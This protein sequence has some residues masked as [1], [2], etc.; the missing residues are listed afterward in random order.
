MAGTPLSEVCDNFMMITKD[1][2]LITLY[3]TSSTDFENYLEG[4]LVSAIKDFSICD[5]SVAYATGVFTETLTQRNIS[6]LAKMMKKYWLEKEVADITQ[7]NLHITDRDYKT[8]SEAQNLTAKKSI[9]ILE[10]E[11]IS[12]LLVNYSLVTNVDWASW[13]AGTFYTP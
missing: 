8:Y 7:M 1:Y 11:E 2:R 4:F 9:L 10:R 6:I 12:Q 13:Y 5:Q 3:N